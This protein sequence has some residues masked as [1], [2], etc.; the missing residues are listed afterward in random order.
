MPYRHR[1]GIVADDSVNLAPSFPGVD[2]LSK[3]D[4]TGGAQISTTATR[5]QIPLCHE[6]WEGGDTRATYRKMVQNLMWASGYD[7]VAIPVAAGVLVP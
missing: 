5:S 7:L 6:S 3:D 4:P 1:R 2:A